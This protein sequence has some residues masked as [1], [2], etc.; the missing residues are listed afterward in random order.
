LLALVPVAIAIAVAGVWISASGAVVHTAFPKQPPKLRSPTSA[1][2][3]I[4]HDAVEFHIRDCMAADGFSYSPRPRNPGFGYRYF[5]YVIDD[6]A[7]A[8]TYGFGREI[9][10]RLD[11]EAEAGTDARYIRSLSRAQLDA[12]GQALTRNR[13]TGLSA[14]NPLGGTVTHSDA[15]CE[16]QAWQQIYGSAEQWFQL[17]TVATNVDSIRESMVRGDKKFGV[18]VRAWSECMRNNGI[19]ATDPGTLQDNQLA[20]TDAAAQPQDIPLATVEAQCA[21]KSGL[22]KTAVELDQLYGAQLH[23]KYRSTYDT[24]Y[25]LQLTALPLARSVV[26]PG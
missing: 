9:T 20:R 12:Y 26:R 8:K 10:A 14:T 22:S 15:G 1:E 6:L 25:R 13:L 4:L 11:R 2:L 21:L 24:L 18:A 23:E 7:W 16:T 3:D 5:P 19:A 17:S